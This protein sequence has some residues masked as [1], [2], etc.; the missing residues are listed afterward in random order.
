MLFLILGANIE[1]N[2][3]NLIDF[4]IM[5]ASIFK[6]LY[7]QDIAKSCIVKYWIRRNKRN[8]VIKKYLSKKCPKL[9]ILIL[10]LKDL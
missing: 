2:E 7:P 1:C 9:I 5:G 10:I 3:K 6:S 8:E 4:S